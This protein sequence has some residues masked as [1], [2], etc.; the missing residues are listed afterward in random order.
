MS[1]TPEELSELLADERDEYRPRGAMD[2]TVA[3]TLDEDDD[4]QRFVG[5][6]I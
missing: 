6:L 1:M 5:G 4:G 3:D 2:M